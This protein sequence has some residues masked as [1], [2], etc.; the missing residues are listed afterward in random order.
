MSELFYRMAAVA[1]SC[2]SSACHARADA[3][4]NQQEAPSLLAK[5]EAYETAMGWIRA[6]LR[7]KDM[8]VE[9]ERK[10]NQKNV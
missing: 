2:E 3:V 10:G 5:A 7:E 9:N 8:S 1:A 6:N 4:C